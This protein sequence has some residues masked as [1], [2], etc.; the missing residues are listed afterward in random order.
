[1]NKP[2]NYGCV[3]F[4]NSG[5]HDDMN[6]YTFIESIAVISDCFINFAKINSK[7]FSE[8]RNFGL[9]IEQRMF[10]RTNDINT[11][12]GAIFLLILLFAGIKNS[13]KYDDISKNIKNLS[14]NIFDDYATSNIDTFGKKIYHSNQIL[15]IR[16]LAYYGFSDILNDYVA[17]YD[18]NNDIN[19]L[20]VYIMSKL[21]DTT[22]VKRSGVLG[23]ALL[24]KEASLA[25]K[26]GNYERLNSYAL[27]NRISCGGC[28]DVL[29]ITLISSLVKQYYY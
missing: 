27:K 1:M 26:N 5:I 12:K 11:Y 22:I 9:V 10:N 28:A 3:G 18:N 2:Y 24:K 7:S 6:Y 13:N 16:G 15:G 14:N 25:L 20:M 19:S 4:N 23:L 29:A 21:D 17:F 8:L